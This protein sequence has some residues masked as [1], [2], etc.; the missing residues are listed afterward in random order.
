MTDIE[1]IIFALDAHAKILK[2]MSEICVNI[3]K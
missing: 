1:K 2:V 3:L